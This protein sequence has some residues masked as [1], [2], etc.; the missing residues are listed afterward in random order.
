MNEEPRQALQTE[1]DPSLGKTAAA[2]FGGAEVR[3]TPRIPSELSILPARGFVMF[4]GTMIPLTITRPASI[5]LLDETLPKTKIIGLLNQRDDEKE[6]P[7]PEDLYEMGTAALVVKLLRQS[8]EQI[9]II[10]QGLSRFK[11]RQVIATEPFLRAEVELPESISPAPSNEWQAEFKNLRESAAR[12]VELTPEAPEQAGAIVRNIEE[13]GQLADF[14]APNLD[15]PVAQKQA[16]LEELDVVKRVRAVQTTI[17]A[18]LEI[19]QIQQRLHQDVQ[20]QFG[21]AHRKAYLR[22][23]LKAIQ[24]E[25]GEGDTG[26]D[27]QI[28]Q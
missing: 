2:E 12:L 20:S 23:Q 5:K 11:I 17:S 26:A 18:Q 13:A 7:T 1:T 19:A 22:G 6:E 15:V 9:V 25:L 10:V 27:E 24:R 4:P 28:A 14:L 16:I 3:S 21:D 8:D